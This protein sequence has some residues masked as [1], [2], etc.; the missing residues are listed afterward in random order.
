MQHS[1]TV[2]GLL[3]CIVLLIGTLVFVFGVAAFFASGM[4][5]SPSAAESSGKTGCIALL[6]GGV[7]IGTSL[8]NL[9]G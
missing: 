6:I 7:I 4:S 9:L 8:F 1:I 3:L 5:D 2:G